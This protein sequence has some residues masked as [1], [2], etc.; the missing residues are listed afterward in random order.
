MLAKIR[1]TIQRY[2]LLNSGDKVLVGV[3]GGP[4]SLALLHCLL[5]FK[6]EYKLKLYVGHLDH[7][8]RGKESAAEAAYVAR[9]AQSWGLPV[10]IEARDVRAYQVERGLT[11]EEAARE[12]R[13]Q[14]LRQAANEVGAGKIAVGHQ[15]NDQAETVLLNL[16]RGSG[17]EGLKAMEPREGDL[18]RPLLEVRRE[19]IEAYC[20]EHGLKPCRDP[21]NLD[22]AYR[23]NKIRLQLLPL[24][25]REYNPAIVDALCRTADI[26]RAEDEVLRQVTVQACKEVII[27]EGGDR[28]V[29][30]AGRFL[31][32]PLGLQRR[33]IRAAATALGWPAGN[34]Y[35]IERARELAQSQGS[36]NW[37]GGGKIQ[38]KGG[39]IF[40]LT[41]MKQEEG[42]LSFCL[43][44]VVPGKT[45]LP[46]LNLEIAAE[47]VPPPG[48][49]PAHNNEA[50][51]DWSKI[52][53]E[54]WV[55]NR[56]PGDYF[57]P[58]GVGGRKKL[59]DFFVD[60]KVPESQ[61][62]AIPLVVDRQGS[63][64]W[65]AGWRIDAR[66]KVTP[67]TREVLH[68]IL[69]KVSSS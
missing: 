56:R 10:K 36:L 18:I 14:F 9:L 62:D 67:A 4:D 13:Y 5:A 60:L 38:L 55:R 6:D 27:E 22:P 47:V 16:L 45:S 3:S 49:F 8:L 52:E 35:H 29:L 11:L 53:G 32:L 48:S 65:V 34:F 23:R 68:L 39:K 51:L 7:K 43:P 40:F 26:L 31:G 44:L 63:I 15:A 1:Q 19:E 61:R 12:V 46:F 57:Y 69:T 64:L 20:R 66:W 42:K 24:L 54:L 21:S 41:P 2:S 50:W 33:V 59:Q 58:L 37:P 30:D 25:A 28:L 17:V